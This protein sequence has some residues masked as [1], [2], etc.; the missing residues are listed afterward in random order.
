MPRPI[1]KQRL[2]SMT[3]AHAKKAI[4]RLVELMDDDNSNVALG[5]CK[6]ILNKTIPDIKNIEVTNV[7]ILN[8]LTTNQKQ[9]AIKEQPI[10]HT[11]LTNE[12]KK[13]RAELLL[14]LAQSELKIGNYRDREIINDTL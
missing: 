3:S 6:T 13:E 9:K 14:A 8:H 12:Q 11:T 2:Y 4:K 7:P 10:K 1:S 5:A